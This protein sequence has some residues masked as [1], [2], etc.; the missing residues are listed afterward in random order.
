MKE[1]MIDKFDI[2]KHMDY[3]KFLQEKYHETIIDD[4]K[5]S[6]AHNEQQ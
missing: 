3:L 5:M 4:M 2:S 1:G 6:I